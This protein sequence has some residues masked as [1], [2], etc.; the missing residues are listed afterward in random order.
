MTKLREKDS[1]SKKATS[2]VIAKKDFV[3]CQNDCFLEIKKG[4]KI[5]D[6]KIPTKFIQ[7]L[8]TEQVI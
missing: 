3:I 1:E 5:D 8:K 6:L 4:D 7:N 2:S